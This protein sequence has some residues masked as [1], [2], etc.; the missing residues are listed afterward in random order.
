MNQSKTEWDLLPLLK[1]ESET[2]KELEKVKKAN[3][4]FVKKWSTR[5]DYIKDPKILKQTLDEYEILLRNYGNSGNPGY[6]YTLKFELDQSDAGIKAKL[7]KIEELE[8]ELRNAKKFFTLNIAK[9]PESE[10]E[11]FF[12][13]SDLEKYKHYL[14]RTFAEAKHLLSE[15]EEKI[16][17][18]KESTSHDFWERLTSGLLA[19]QEAKIK[20]KG[21]QQTKNFSDLLGLLDDPDK[22]TRKEA[23][24][25][26]T[27][28]LDR[29]TEIAEPEINAILSNKKTD[30]TLR[31][32]ARADSARH[33]EDDIESEVVDAVITAVTSRFDISRRFY[34]LKA[35]LLGLK[36]IQYYEKNVSYGKNIPEYK[37]EESVELVKKTF[38]NLDNQFLQIFEMY[39]QNGQIDAF[40][41]K[42]KRNGAFCIHQLITQPTYIMLNHTNTLKDVTTIAHEVGHGINNELMRSK[43][44]ALYFET[45][46]STA[47]VASTFMEDF[48]LQELLKE[49]NEEQKLSI[50][51]EKLNGEIASIF[52]QTAFYNFETELHNTFREKGY[53]SKEEV[54]KM[55]KGHMSSYLGEMVDTSE[56]DNWWIYV[57]HFRYMFYVYSYV[58]GELI[59]K[60]LQAQVRKDRKFVEKVKEFL[61]AG[62]S[63]SPK[64]IF[65]NLGID[66]TKKEFWLQGIKEIE[67]LLNETESLAKRLKKI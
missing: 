6:F 65:A 40:P 14:R 60:Y 32:F 24:T 25:A 21:K 17:T 19:K 26:L 1:S 5:T 37:W 9:I 31:K 61:S 18:L 57:P 36:K 59:S 42:G 3:Q 66:I 52:R 46:K 53:L 2:E 4:E 15:P 16:L 28:I 7:N 55:F 8:K 47:E 56:T 45:P 54:G 38:S 64:N 13:Y 34:K 43:Q 62:T 27:K 49:S 63:D 11:K 48:V 33:L 44:H 29:Y 12:S 51:M 20:I 10:Q 50:L 58:S 41:K 23:N 35:E 67:D 22:E 30:D 39:L